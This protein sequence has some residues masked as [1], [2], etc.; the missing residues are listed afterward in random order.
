MGQYYKNGTL[1]AASKKGSFW[2]RDTIKFLD[3]FKGIASPQIGNG[4]TIL[5]WDDLWSGMVPQQAYPELY[6]FAKNSNITLY[7]VSQLS[8][9]LEAFYIPL[10]TQAYV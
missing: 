10:L 2:W 1:I 8:H 9:L 4:S 3:S 5:L 7:E 6:S